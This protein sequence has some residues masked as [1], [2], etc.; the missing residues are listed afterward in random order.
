MF[1]RGP[2]DVGP[3]LPETKACHT[4]YYIIIDEQGKTLLPF[5]LYFKLSEMS[6]TADCI[7]TPISMLLIIINYR[8]GIKE[9]KQEI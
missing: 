1:P 3:V 9:P 4:V 7:L 8:K 2:M 6:L 5:I